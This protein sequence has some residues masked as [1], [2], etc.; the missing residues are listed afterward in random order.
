MSR[1][2]LSVYFVVDP[3]VCAGRQIGPVVEAAVQSGVTAIQLRD[4]S[5]DRSLVLE[6][7]R[8]LRSVLSGTG[9]PLIINDYLDVA[10]DV[11]ADG[12]HLGQGDGDPLSARALLGVGAIIGVTAFTVDHFKALDPNV[13]DYAGTGP[14]FPTLTKPNKP[15]L[16]A[17][18]F[19]VLVQM[20]PVPVVGIGGVKPENAGEV[21]RA[22]AQGVAMMRAISEAK[23]PGVAAQAFV[24]TV[25][26]ARQ[27]KGG[28]AA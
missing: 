9:V 20:S 1:L 2:D 23:D 8:M 21:I 12:V 22:G 13:V 10:L 3:S 18:K 15:V 11:G 5:G 6:R 19:S 28:R 4:K 14:F 24:H 26:T 25:E 16:G 7:A 17:D 27:E